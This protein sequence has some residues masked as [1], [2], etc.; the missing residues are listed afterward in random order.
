MT[1]SKRFLVEK[2]CFS[3]TEWHRTE[4]N[5]EPRRFILNLPL[6]DD[7]FYILS[8]YRFTILSFYALSFVFH[9]LLSLILVGELSFY[10]FSLH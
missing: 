8:F 9:I 6:D 4:E 2:V 1:T 10:T 3:Y 5:V 7:D